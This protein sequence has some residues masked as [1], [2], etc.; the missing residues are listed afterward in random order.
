MSKVNITLVKYRGTNKSC[1]IDFDTNATI[2]D[3]KIW[4]AQKFKVKLMRIMVLPN[5]E[6]LFDDDEHN[7]WDLVDYMDK[8]LNNDELIKG[9]EPIFYVIVMKSSLAFITNFIGFRNYNKKQYVHLT[10]KN[11]QY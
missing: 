8:R 10:D 9:K 2:L 7:D 6:Y 3:I 11:V 1:V 5:I 4:W